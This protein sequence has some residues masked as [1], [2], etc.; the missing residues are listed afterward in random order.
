MSG[1]QLKVL[2][3]CEGF[4]DIRLVVGLAGICDLTLV[5]PAWEFH[6]SGLADRITQSG[7]SLKVDAI[8]GRRPVFQARSF[9][10]LLNNIRKYDVVLSEGMVRGSLNSTIVGKVMNVPV[11][12]YLNIA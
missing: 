10:Y 2:Y 8:E 7:A 5:T 6:A 11:V 1:P 12:T 3:F 4:T 9:V